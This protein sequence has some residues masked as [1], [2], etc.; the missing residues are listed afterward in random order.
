[1]RK[2]SETSFDNWTKNEQKTLQI[3]SKQDIYHSSMITLKDQKYQ[4]IFKHVDTELKILWTTHKDIVYAINE[5]NADEQNGTI[6]YDLIATCTSV[7][8]WTQR[9]VVTFCPL[10]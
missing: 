1:M 9:Q 10:F 6:F 4:Q 8:K 5:D 2:L 7:D 3:Q